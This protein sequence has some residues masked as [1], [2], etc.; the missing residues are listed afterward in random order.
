[1]RALDRKLLRDLWY[2]RGQALAI[3][4]VIGAGLAAVLMSISTL[5]SLQTTRAI[6]YRDYGFA[7]IFASLKRAPESLGERIAALPGVDRVAT[8]VWAPVTIE[9]AGFTDPVSGLLVSAPRAGRADLN[10]L[11][12]RAGRLLDPNRSDEVIIGDAFAEAHAF[13]PGDRLGV[14]VNGKRKQLNIVGIALSPE[15]IYQIS[16]HAIF[17]DFARFGVLWM[18]HDALATAFDMDG[19]FNNVTLTLARGAREADVIERLDAVLERY[20]GLG[21]YGREDQLS[22]RFLSQEFTQ[23]EQMGRTFSV[24]F[25]GVA[26]FL[27]NMVVTR[28]V[29]TQREE[30][31]TLK[32]FGYSNASIGLHYA[33]LVVAIV[34]LGIVAGVAA[35]IWLGQGLSHTYMEYYRFPYLHFQLRPSIVLGAT[36]TTAVAALIG[37]VF[38]VRRAVRLPPAQAMRPEPPPLYRATLMERLGLQR[39]L[40]QPSRM[41]LRHIERRPVKSALSVLGIGLAGGI[42]ISGT[43]MTDAVDFMVEAEFRMAQRE[44]IAVSFTEPTSYRALHELAALPG[45]TRV[46]PVRAVPVRLRHGQHIYRTAIQGLAPDA[47]LHRTLDTH[48]Q[49]VSF[50]PDGIVLTD[51][52]GTRLDLKPGDLLTVEVLDGSQPVREVPVVGFVQQYIGTGG[53]MDLAALNRLLREDRAI[54][55]AFLAVDAHQRENVYARLKKMPRVA[56]VQ[57]HE[58]A[59]RNYYASIGDLLLTF[60]TFIAGLA[61]AITFGVVYNSARI[62]LSERSRELASLRVLGFTRGE[63]AYILLGELA[64]LTLAAIPLG[65]MVGRALSAHFIA[66]IHQELFRVPLVLNPDTYA[67]SAGIVLA[68]AIIS[69]LIVRRRLDRLDLIAVLKTKE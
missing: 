42:V 58:N 25:L 48:L 10:R 59:I 7:H 6:Y 63:I 15:F 31:A 30:I 60:M 32:A 34:L 64:L 51:Y 4:L 44:D 37:T 19:A 29:S 65:F 57:V 28:L 54:T 17:P 66:T 33:K 23:L 3:A 27:L 14:I 69:G 24:I 53:Y 62:T 45:V 38:A 5:D 20:G 47:D 41:I 56:G 61:G 49:P 13:K 16:P 26:V 46:E 40:S 43:F 50:P 21:A 11:Y 55:G 36:L 9:I 35:G 8:R 18:A 12:L 67:L 22:H 52:L 68:S 1:M 39:W 2:L